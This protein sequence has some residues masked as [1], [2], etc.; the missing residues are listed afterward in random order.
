[1]E[2]IE[3]LEYTISTKL[4]IIKFNK[5]I[6]TLDVSDKNEIFN[7][8]QKWEYFYKKENPNY[9]LDNCFTN[10]I[11]NIHND[12]NLKKLGNYIYLKEGYHFIKFIKNIMKNIW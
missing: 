4:F 6:D 2:N 12:K 11:L 9:K 10:Y 1:M 7:L 3:D 8:I 5:Y